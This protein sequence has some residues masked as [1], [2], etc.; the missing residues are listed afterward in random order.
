MRRYGGDRFARLN[1]AKSVM[2]MSTTFVPLKGKLLG[3]LNF[4]HPSREM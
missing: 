2:I 4:G 3:L 1:T